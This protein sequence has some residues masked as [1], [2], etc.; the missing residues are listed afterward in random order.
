MERHSLYRYIEL[1]IM[2]VN[3]ARENLPLTR[4]EEEILNMLDEYDYIF[5]EWFEE[6]VV[7]NEK[8]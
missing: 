4:I 3:N 5:E 1:I 7:E 8:K 6:D 2:A